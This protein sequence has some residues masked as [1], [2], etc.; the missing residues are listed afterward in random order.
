MTIDRVAEPHGIRVALRAIELKLDGTKAAAATAVRK[1]AALSAV[2]SHAVESQYL[3]HNPLRDVRRKRQPVE[4]AVDPRVVVNPEQ[5][6]ALLKAVQAIAP[7]LHAYFATIY[8]AAARPAEARNLRRRDLH[9]PASGWGRI[10]LAGSY[11]ER[12]A[13][14]TGDGARSEERQLKHRPRKAI[15][16]VPAHPALVNAFRAH[17]AT[18]DTPPD[19]RLFV[20]RTGRGGKKLDPPY[21]EPAGAS[22]IY[23]VWAAARRE[24][25]T[26]EQVASP[27]AAR[28][29]DLRHA[30]VSTWLAAGVAP[31]QVAEW[32]GHGVDVLLRVYAKCLDNSEQA[33]LDRIDAAFSMP[34]AAS[35]PARRAR[36]AAEPPPHPRPPSGRGADLHLF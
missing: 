12:G 29:Y 25:L 5:A 31:T 35:S 15:G 32:A 30:A 13:A 28:P 22:R 2:L 4:D 7:D 24:A 20:A 19:G 14:W 3:P 8:Y 17:L 11:Q 6:R 27:L 33:A 26:A 10:T 23:R 1:R 16:P 36:M 9:L 21:T 34:S 18:Y